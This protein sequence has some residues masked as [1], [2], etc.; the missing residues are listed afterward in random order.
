[1]LQSDAAQPVR[2]GCFCRRLPEQAS[3]VAVCSAV[4]L[5]YSLQARDVEKD[6]IPTCRELGIGI[7]V[8]PQ[9][10]AAADAV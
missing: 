6:L 2:S 1:M 5:E 10:P 3:V 4:Q 8:R 9:M 7:V